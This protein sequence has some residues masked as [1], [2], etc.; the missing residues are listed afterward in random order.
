MSCQRCG[1]CCR[2][3]SITMVRNEDF[4]RFL[5]YHGLHLRDRQDGHME[6]YGE[7]KCRYLKSD[8]KQ[9]SRYTCAIYENR[10][11][12]CRNW[13]CGEWIRK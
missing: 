11:N 10:P 12:I 6:V 4:A 2:E 13:Q 8:P 3:Y 9:P 1:K 5:T 7:E